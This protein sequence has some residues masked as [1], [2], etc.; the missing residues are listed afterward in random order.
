[1][2]FRL[3]DVNDGFKVVDGDIEYVTGFEIV[4]LLNELDKKVKFQD[5][6][7]DKSIRFEKSQEFRIEELEKEK[8]VLK[9][10]IG[11]LRKIIGELQS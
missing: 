10:E 1:M 8:S 11:I 9:Q 2:R 3:N 6:V 7:I 5:R 4:R